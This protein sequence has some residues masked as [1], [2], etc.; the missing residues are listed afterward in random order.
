MTD[1][2]TPKKR[3]LSKQIK[4]WHITALII[5]AGCYLMLQIALSHKSSISPPTPNAEKQSS[6]HVETN[7]ENSQ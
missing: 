1:K 4:P 2:L 3:L 6:I 7:K 5:I